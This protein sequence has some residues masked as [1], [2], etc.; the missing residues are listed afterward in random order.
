M[1]FSFL[2]QLFWIKEEEAITG[3][4]KKVTEA[5]AWIKLLSH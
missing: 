5:I 2:S 3:I 1:G 4:S